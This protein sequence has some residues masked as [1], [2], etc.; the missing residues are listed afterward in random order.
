M[1][2]A[3]R[4]G[5]GAHDR[6]WAPQ[7]APVR[8]SLGGCLRAVATVVL[9][10]AGLAVLGF[11]WL[12]VSLQQS[13]KAP[14]AV[15]APVSWTSRDVVLSPDRPIVHGH[16]TLT[17]RSGPPTAVRVG[18]NAGV[19]STVAE[20]SPIG[21][22]RTSTSAG[23]PPAALLAGPSVRLT[24]GISSGSP[25]SCLAPC[26]LQ[27]PPQF[28]CASGSCRISVD[29][30]IELVPRAKASSGAVRVSVAGGASASLDGHLPDGLVIDLALDS[31]VAPGGG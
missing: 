26:E 30:V 14:Q 22:A 18:L 5:P 4:P 25:Q 6:D 17:A 13:Y 12:Y 20:P 10:L 29:V 19:P 7:Q 28:D 3:A 31:P 8:L 27:V 24:S 21:S 23:V 9:I 11:I 15:V 2:Q 1:S 16:L